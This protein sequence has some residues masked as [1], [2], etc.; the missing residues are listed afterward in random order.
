MPSQKKE[1]ETPQEGLNMYRGLEYGYEWNQTLT[2]PLYKHGVLPGR[3]YS[4][5]GWEVL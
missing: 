1:G 2:L 4:Y 3:I 5:R